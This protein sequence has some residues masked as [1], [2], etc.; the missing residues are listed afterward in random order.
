MQTAVLD[1]L[2][3]A[4]SDTA[5]LTQV[6]QVLKDEHLRLGAR[7]NLKVSS[8]DLTFTANDPTVDLPADFQA[9]IA[10]RTGST[11]MQPVTHQELMLLEAGVQNSDLVDS[12]AS[13]WYAF[14]GASAIR[15]FPTPSKTSSTGARIWYVARPTAMSADGDTPEGLPTEW[16]QLLVEMAIYRIAL[17]EEESG[18]ASAAKASADELRMDFERFLKGRGGPAGSRLRLRHYE[19]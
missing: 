16:H 11:R 18:L 13:G 1:R 3:V 12:V 7:L 15:V 6:K 9:V 14:E 19:G 10:L 8:A 5:K 2:S 17:A 4:A